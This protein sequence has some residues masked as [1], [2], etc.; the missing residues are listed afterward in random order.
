MPRRAPALFCSIHELAAVGHRQVARNRHPKIER[1]IGQRNRPV[2]L[3]RGDRDHGKRVG[4]GPHDRELGVDMVFDVER[5]GLGVTD[6]VTGIRD[7]KP[8]PAVCRDRFGHLEEGPVHLFLRRIG[9]RDDFLPKGDL[10]SVRRLDPLETH[11]AAEQKRGLLIWILR[12]IFDL[13]SGG[14]GQ[15]LCLIVDVDGEL[16]CAQAQARLGLARLLRHG[17]MR[18]EKKRK[19]QGGQESQFGLE[20]PSNTLLRRVRPT[21]A[22][23]IGSRRERSGSPARATFQRM[24]DVR[25]SQ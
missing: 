5:A 10:G 20:S 2:L 21:A 13:E 4:V 11:Q 25:R 24:R 1:K 16:D 17:R 23:G 22:R 18:V 12:K 19:D 14:A 3:L 6:E 15:S 7:S 9:E 8:R